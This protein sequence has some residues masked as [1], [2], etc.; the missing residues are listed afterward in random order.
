MM[1]TPDPGRRRLA[2]AGPT[3]RRWLAVAITVLVLARVSGPWAN[4]APA[5]QAANLVRNGDFHQA[6]PTK[7][8]PLGWTTKHPR[9]V[10]LVTDNRFGHVIAMQG[11]ARLMGSYG[12]DLLSDKIAFDPRHHYKVTGFTRSR[13]PRM[14]LFVK[15]YAT[16]THHVNGRPITRDE[17]VFQMRKEIHPT[18]DWT[19]F[20]LDL[21]IK[22]LAMA[23]EFQ[24]PIQYLRVELWAYWPKGTCSWADIAMRDAGELP[25]SEQFG[26]KAVTTTHPLTGQEP[27]KEPPTSQPVQQP[28]ATGR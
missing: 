17:A 8:L 20:T 16:L 12:V 7:N 5:S 28:T 6:A 1:P 18:R 4:A 15:G 14:I 11:D 25:K 2:P 13:G 24:H 3:A 26:D 19:P 27:V 22:P 23:L 9:N 10:R 21:K